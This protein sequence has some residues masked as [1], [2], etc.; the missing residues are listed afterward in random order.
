MH[1]HAKSQQPA[2]LKSQP[3]SL[4]TGIA[5]TQRAVGLI[6]TGIDHLP[7]DN[8]LLCGMLHMGNHVVV[9]SC[10][11]RDNKYSTLSIII[12]IFALTPIT[13]LQ[14]TE[15]PLPC[16]L[17]CMAPLVSRILQRLLKLQKLVMEAL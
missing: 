10:Y 7:C 8:H 11:S 1:V 6:D 4:P 16:G 9:I 15:Q 12:T 3:P 2:M 13:I 14:C 17:C 5:D